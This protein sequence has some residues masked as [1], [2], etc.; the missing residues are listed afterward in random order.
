MSQGASFP[1]RG[2]FIFT[3][4]TEASAAKVTVMVKG[5]NHETEPKKF[6]VLTSAQP[7]SLG[8]DPIQ[9]NLSPAD[10]RV[11]LND[12]LPPQVGVVPK[13]RIGRRWINVLWALPLGFVLAV[14]GV[15]VAQ[16]LRELPAV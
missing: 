16:G 1:C 7:A 9:A 8:H 14:I 6:A 10:D 3:D 15:A 5:Q 2:R 11:L 12:W 4:R 13:I